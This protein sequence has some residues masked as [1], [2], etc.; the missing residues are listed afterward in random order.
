MIDKKTR[1]KII[2]LKEDGCS[3]TEVKKKTGASLPTIRKILKEAGFKKV[4]SDRSSAPSPNLNLSDLEI[5]LRNLESKFKGFNETADLKDR[6][7]K[8]RFSINFTNIFPRGR[9]EDIWKTLSNG[10]SMWRYRE[11]LA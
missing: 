10:T 5:R 9:C 2:K 3:N 8:H 11:L 6:Q 4:V 7:I 1:E